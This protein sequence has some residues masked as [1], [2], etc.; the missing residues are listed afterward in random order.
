MANRFNLPILV[1][2]VAG[3]SLLGCAGK[4]GVGDLGKFYTEAAMRHGPQQNPVILIPGIL[5]SRLIERDTSDS[6]RSTLVWG[7]LNRGLADP[8]QPV[9][10]RL[11]A[12]PMRP[13]ASLA[14]LTDD[15][16]PDGAI[17]RFSATVL[18]LPVYS[19]AYASILATLG[20]GGYMDS[21]LGESGA[22]DY[23][24]DHYTCFQFDYDWRRDN[25]ENAHALLAFIEEKRRFVQAHFAEDYGG[26]PEDYDVKFDLVAHSMGAVLTR[27]MLRYGDAELPDGDELPRVTW[28]GAEGVERVVLV[29]PPNAGSLDAMKKLVE[30]FQPAPFNPRYDAAILGTTPSIYQL[31]PR[32]RH[33]LILAELEPGATPEAI[34]PLDPAVWERLG[35]GLGASGHDR[36]LA[37][38]LP[39]VD[40][41]ERRHAIAMDHLK[42]C[43]DRAR[44]FQAAIDEPASLPEGLTLTLYAGDGVATPHKLVVRANGKIKV[45]D[46]APGDGTVTRHSAL[47]DERLDG[48]WTPRLRTPIEWTDVNFLARDH[49]GLTADPAFADNVLHLLLESP[50]IVP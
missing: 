45:L 18:G 44:R 5:G 2:F 43:L 10:A 4:D 25:V 48:D 14:E 35:I 23:G 37:W 41:V 9:G 26:E 20:V 17:E 32:A 22:I 31:L 38:L 19:D 15:V 34:D 7:S 13:G 16:E 24:S 29:A 36:V 39:E 40:S 27:Y 30:G 1:C 28:A 47:M 21:Q 12:I 8:S 42:K 33:G 11:M 3:L 6:S 50:H 46:T 49:V